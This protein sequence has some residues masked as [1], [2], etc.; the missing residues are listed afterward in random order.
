[1]RRIEWKR[2]RREQKDGRKNGAE[3]ECIDKEEEMKNKVAR[4][5]S[6]EQDK[7]RTR[8]TKDDNGGKRE[9]GKEK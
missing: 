4:K 5:E 8:E 6:Q 1:M 3:S 7:K 9:K 2:K